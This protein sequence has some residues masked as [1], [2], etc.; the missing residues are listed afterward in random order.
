MRVIVIGAGI[1]GL[2][3]ALSL[4]AAGIEVAV[5]EAVDRPRPLG[6]GINL[7]PH[8]VRELTE[9]GLGDKLDDIG[10]PTSELVHFDRHG[11]R[12]WSEARGRALGYRWPQY[13]IHR[14][15][16]QMILLDA[17]RE[18]I[19]SSTLHLGTRFDGVDE[20]PGGVHARV[21]DR[22]SGQTA[23][24]T[25]D[26][27][28]GADGINST[29]R[30]QLHPKQPPLHFDGIR[31]WRGVTEADPFLT[32]RS[33]AAAGSNAAT[34]FV[35]YPISKRAERRGRALV[36]WVAEVRQPSGSHDT[37][38]DWTRGGAAEEVLPYFEKWRFDWLDV[39]ELIR[40]AE[41]VLDYPMVDRD[42]LLSW[43]TE[44]VNLL[45]DAAHPMYPIGSN[46]GSQA[47]IDGR[48]LAFELATAGE[49]TGGLR[50]YET[51]R[52]D[53]TNALVRANRSMP[54]DR[55]LQT[56]DERAPDGFRHI[57]D[58]LTPEELDTLRHAYQQT[59]AVDVHTLNNQQSWTPRVSNQQHQGSDDTGGPAVSP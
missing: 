11:N 5:V 43:G 1:G 19:G 10:I 15:E 51:Q 56:V 57:E 8:A 9:L 34:K 49:P 27:L 12:I 20:V 14:G 30:A 22:R 54:A 2:T 46:G 3:A 24:V 36:N 32:G 21:A 17:V 28:I 48:V 31:M 55:V 38:P 47:V 33:M 40:R 44:R 39:P 53:V 37:E 4:Q 18:R 58:V 35:A 7:Q 23:T 6:V 16:L 26:V 13:S 59:T 42:P 29:V 45:G 50:A 25:G 41:A 52:R